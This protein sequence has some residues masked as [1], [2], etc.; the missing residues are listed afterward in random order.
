MSLESDGGIILT[1]ENRITRRKTCPSTT[2]ST[3]NPAWI[4]PGPNPSLRGERPETN[5]LSHGAALESVLIR[6]RNLKCEAANVLIRTV[7]PLM[8][9]M[10]RKVEIAVE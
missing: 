4:D 5:D 10:F 1:G 7:E 8:M 2:L 6:L 3:T 9:M